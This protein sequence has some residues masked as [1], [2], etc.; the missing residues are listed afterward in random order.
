[1]FVHDVREIDPADTARYG[2]KGAGLARMCR[3]GLPV[4]PA[5]VIDTEACRWS[6]EN[7]GA[8]PPELTAQVAEGIAMLE[9]ET[10]R[11]FAADEGVPLLVS[12]RSG[13]KVSMPGMMDTVLNLGLDRSG[14]LRL[15][16]EAGTASDRLAGSPGA[17]FAVDSWVRFWAMFADIVLDVDP[18]YLRE[19]PRPP[20]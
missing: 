19:Q 8:L 1:M 9:R 6:R 16:A 20:T 17:A 13:A 3:L 18:E 14:V 12:V 11:R 7:G 10:G 2:G 5:F 15:A 4:P